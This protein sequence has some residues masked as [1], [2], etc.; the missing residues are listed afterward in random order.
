MRLKPVAEALG[1]TGLSPVAAHVPLDRLQGGRTQVVRELK[2]VGCERV[3]VGPLHEAH[4]ED[5]SSV[6]RMATRLSALGGRLA[7]DNR[8]LC[9][10]NDRRELDG[11]GFDLLADR[12]GEGLA[13]AF[14]AGAAAA[15]GRNPATALDCLDGRVPIV[16]LG[17][18]TSDGG[19]DDGRVDLAAVVAAARE[20]GAEWLVHAPPAFD[21]ATLERGADALASLPE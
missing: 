6:A 7:A 3:V 4:F 2:T 18:L 5:E 21:A 12:A 1:R 17:S 14:D 11:D 10:R 13:F 15:A 20:A 19:P 9:Y 16:Q 8:R